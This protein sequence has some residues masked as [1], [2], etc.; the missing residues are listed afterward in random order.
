MEFKLQSVGY[1]ENAQRILQI[2]PMLKDMSIRIE[3]Y[4]DY[5]EEERERLFIT[6]ESLEELMGLKKSLGKEII[7]Y[8]DKDEMESADYVPTLEIYDYWRE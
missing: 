7:I 2:Y 1:Y 6:L 8:G 4:L 5:Y 3:K